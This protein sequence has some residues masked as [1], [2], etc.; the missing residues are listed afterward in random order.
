MFLFFIFTV[1]L[2]YIKYL[3]QNNQTMDED[4]DWSW[5]CTQ[6]TS[7]T[8]DRA[9]NEDKREQNVRIFKC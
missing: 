9:D 8:D 7:N 6:A 4:D 1:V 3:I 5:M 2:G